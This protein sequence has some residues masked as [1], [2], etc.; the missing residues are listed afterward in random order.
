MLYTLS[1]EKVASPGLST[2]PSTLPKR[3][4]KGPFAAKAPTAGVLLCPVARIHWSPIAV[5]VELPAELVMLALFVILAANPETA[6]FAP[7]DAPPS[8]TRVLPPVGFCDD[9]TEHIR[10]NRD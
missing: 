7:Q 5:L 6:L 3:P 1:R 2:A 4:R 9:F 10:R 8:G